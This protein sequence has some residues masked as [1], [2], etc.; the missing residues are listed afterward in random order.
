M[1]MRIAPI[2]GS[3]L[4]GDGSPCAR[5]RIIDR[6][7]AAGAR[8]PDE[9]AR[10]ACMALREP[11]RRRGAAVEGAADAGAQGGRGADRD[12]GRQPQLPRPADGAE[13]VPVQAAPAVRARLRVRRRGRGGGRRREASQGR[14]SGRRDRLERRLRHPCL[15]RRRRRDAAAAGLRLRRCLGLRHDLRHDPPRPDRPGPAQGRRDAARARRGRRGRHG[16]DPDRQGPRRPRDRGR[17]ERREVRLLQI[18]RRRRDDQLHQPAT[19]A[20]S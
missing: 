7:G 1:R 9:E 2:V 3:R 12:Q 19:S 18:A 20:T 10:H 17:V 6:E 4:R 14:R 15:R 16:G 13:Q 11:D 5:L 8:L